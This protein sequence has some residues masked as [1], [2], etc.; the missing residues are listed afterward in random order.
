[1]KKYLKIT[2][3]AIMVILMSFVNVYAA[4]EPTAATVTLNPSKTEVN[5]G[6]TFTVTMLVKCETGICDF[7]GVLK[8][9]K[10]QIELD[11]YNVTVDKNFSDMSKENEQNDY[12][13]TFMQKGKEEPKE[14]N[15]VTLKFKVLDNVKVDDKINISVSNIQ[16]KDS[17]YNWIEVEAKSTTV[18]VANNQGTTK[19]GD[20]N[21]TDPG[22]TTNPGNT[23]KP[24][25]NADN[26]QA[27][28]V[29]NYAGLENYAFAIIAGV[30]LV[31][32]VAYAKYKQYK[33]I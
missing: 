14:V 17:N 30:I 16:F 26:T 3:L 8:Y 5:K 32:C 12:Q 18:T 28:K 6:E 2:I 4:D 31:A 15:I 21:T 27:N 33:N 22:N 1:M 24:G 20:G 19:P 7:D 23:T 10:A 13:L 11:K 29:I 25:N 9:D